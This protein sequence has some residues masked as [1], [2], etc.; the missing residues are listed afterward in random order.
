M[1][2]QA[3]SAQKGQAGVQLA[4]T[5]PTLKATARANP[6][7]RTVARQ[8][9]CAAPATPRLLTPAA[10]APGTISRFAQ[11]A[12]HASMMP[13][14][15]LHRIRRTHM[16]AFE[17]RASLAEWQQPLQQQKICPT[18]ASYKLMQL[19]MYCSA[20]ASILWQS[21]LQRLLVVIQ[22]CYRLELQRQLF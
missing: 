17:I 20:V 10:R 7:L 22:P 8:A 11:T 3:P 18:A 15:S 5:V 4:T 12:A 16:Q 19:Y 14:S 9:V 1:C 13:P 2:L 6:C 21:W